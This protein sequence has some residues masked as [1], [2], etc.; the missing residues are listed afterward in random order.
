M[1]KGNTMRHTIRLFMCIVVLTYTTASVSATQTII[2]D[3]GTNT[4]AIYGF[5]TSTEFFTALPLEQAYYPG[6]AHTALAM[7]ASG[8]INYDVGKLTFTFFTDSTESK[9]VNI[10]C[11]HADGTLGPA[12]SPT[13]SNEG[14]ETIPYTP[15]LRTSDRSRKLTFDSNGSLNQV[16]TNNGKAGRYYEDTYYLG[17]DVSSA[18]AKHASIEH[19]YT[20]SFVMTVMT[21]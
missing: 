16:F 4:M 19:G 13:V 15:Y 17:I 20:T 5:V 1:P 10:Q 2:P 9:T 6:T 3:Q 12:F 21:Q 7:P 8:L 18:N 11:M 14:T